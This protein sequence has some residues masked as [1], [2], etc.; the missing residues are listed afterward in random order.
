MRIAEMP[1]MNNPSDVWPGPRLLVPISVEALVVSQTDQN[2]DPN[3]PAWSIAP[4]Q[5][6]FGLSY[7][8]IEP[9]P[10][11]GTGVAPPT[12]VTLHWALPDALTHGRQQSG[13]PPGDGGGIQFPLTPNRWLIVRTSPNPQSPP[14]SP[15]PGSRIARAWIV[16][17]DYL[18]D[19]GSN[20][21]L[22]PDNPQV[23]TN[24]G[25]SSTLEEWQGESSPPAASFL[26]AVGPGDATFAAYI[27][28]I[29]NVFSFQDDLSDLTGSPPNNVTNPIALNYLVAGWYADPTTD[30]LYG[31]TD[32]QTWLTLMNELKWSLDNTSDNPNSPPQGLPSP[33]PRQVLCHGMVYD[34]QWYG[35]GPN[36]PSQ[37]GVP[38][39]DPEP[40]IAIGN[41]SIDALAAL[42]EYQINQV[43]PPGVGANVARVLEAFQYNLL[44]TLDEAGG[45]DKL[46]QQIHDAWFGSAPGGTIWEVIKPPP[47]HSPPAPGRESP[48]SFG[49]VP[50]SPPEA[51]LLEQL[52]D[53]Q[54]EL[55]RLDRLLPAA[56]YELYALWWKTGYCAAQNTFSPPEGCG[57]LPDL[58]PQIEAVQELRN[59]TIPQATALRDDLQT[60]LA[61][62]LKSPLALV[63][64]SRP[65]FWQPLDPVVLVYGAGRSYKHGEDGRFSEDGTLFCRMTGQTISSITVA[66]PSTSGPPSAT[67]TVGNLVSPPPIPTGGPVPLE[68]PSLI[69]EAFFLDT[70]NADT[71]ATTALELLSLPADPAAVESLAATVRKQQTL[72]WNKDFQPGNPLDPPTVAELSGLDGTLP[73][74]IAVMPWAAPWSP[75]YLDWEIEWT[76]SANQPASPPSS[77]L[78]NWQFNGL[79]YEWGGGLDAGPTET[80]SG[81]TL[82]TPQ[83]AGALQDRL[84]QFFQEESLMPPSA[85]PPDWLPVTLK[86]LGEFLATVG[87]WDLLSQSLSG[88]HQYLIMRDPGQRILP[89][90]DIANVVDS[91]T[92]ALPI[93]GASF[94]PVRAGHFKLTKLWIVDDFGQIFNPIAMSHQNPAVYQPI[95]S[96]WLQ[97]PPSVPDNLQL[98]QLAP[99][100]AQLGRLSFRFSSAQPG[101]G[102]SSSD[103]DTSPVCG[104]LLPNHLDQSLMVYDAGGNALGE[105]LLTGVAA[106]LRTRWDPAPDSPSA[107]GAPVNIAN[108]YLCGFVEGLLNQPGGGGAA[109]LEL[110]AVVDAT[111]WTIDPLGGSGNQGLSV[112]IGNPLALVRARLTL[113]LDGPPVYDQSLP[114]TGQ[115]VTAAFTE[116]DFPVRLGSLVLRDDGLLGYFLDSDFSQ[117]NSV[118]NPYDFV[119]PP[120]TSP[121]NV[122]VVQNDV[123]LQFNSDLTSPPG[124]QS[125]ACVTMVLDPRGSV[126][127]SAGILPVKSITLPPYYVSPALTRMEVTF[128][129][130]PLL[131]DPETLRMPLPAEKQGQW[132]WLQRSDVTT[133]AT[134]DAGIVK[135]DATARLST[136]PQIVR[137]GWLK[138]SGALGKKT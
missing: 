75:L 15:P 77:V 58:Q 119:S 20:E 44:P 33:L 93:P 40:L 98:V 100:V 28:N 126:H 137:E 71:I 84:A 18:G 118:Y 51:A 95:V 60:K 104:W 8:S 88:F 53:A 61:A 7:G 16:Q 63:N 121:P 131:S 6:Q 82:L 112:L 55:D 108:D 41:T 46:N 2:I 113:E 66:S 110:L 17:S 45:S 32:E 76:S 117:F 22:R 64:R 127:A 5:Y 70:G 43:S 123:R 83:A 94:Y 105:L 13:S 138:L 23:V 99:R 106:N 102:E 25:R 80:I 36:A 86:A 65:R 92:Q 103:P 29:N 3:N 59:T 12:G 49:P 56:Q 52:N 97:T 39:G 27:A 91:A 54:T 101:G 111:T 125:N 62:M 68:I 136:R 26:Q 114:A 31:A 69:V 9:G 78:A 4:M 74:L 37:S 11:T 38:T 124:S 81:R 57:S 128:R 89:G 48:P 107:V 109:L 1:E 73:S 116:I 96:Q 133:W 122:Y 21:F 72:I 34:V 42:I 87:N 90:A 30:P 135:A 47:I 14:S 134:P 120:K 132:Q 129:T 10:F 85:S 130:G 35:P 19:D 115:G 79:D 50:L 24:L 67:V